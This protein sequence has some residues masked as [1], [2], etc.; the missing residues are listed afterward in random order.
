MRSFAVVLSKGFKLAC[1]LYVTII[2]TSLAFQLN[3]IPMKRCH[4]QRVFTRN[5][6]IPP[7]SDLVAQLH[8]SSLGVEHTLSTQPATV[9]LS[10]DIDNIRQ[11]V[12]LVVSLLVIADILLGSP[13][14]NAVA[15]PLRAGIEGEDP[16]KTFRASGITDSD[17]RVDSR[18]IAEEA[19]E[20]ARNSQELRAYLE[21]TKTDQDRM[22]EMR[23]EIDKQIAAL[24][25]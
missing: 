25:D 14:L 7:K 13:I 15:A 8:P 24:D 17:E 1:L 3:H 5:T 23:K 19:L 2:N 9:F 16:Q 4:R 11:Y 20:K 10:L 6:S 18:K 12:P 22:V 21:R